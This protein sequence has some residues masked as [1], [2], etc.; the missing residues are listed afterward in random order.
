MRPIAKPILAAVGAAVM[1]G[2]SA[3]A[4]APAFARDG[5]WMAHESTKL[6]MN[7][8]SR[9][10]MSTRKEARDAGGRSVWNQVAENPDFRATTRPGGFDSESDCRIV[11]WR[12]VCDR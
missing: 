10:H 12:I 1:V 5:G 3:S 4:T 2:L 11:N 9:F 6:M 7:N 8:E